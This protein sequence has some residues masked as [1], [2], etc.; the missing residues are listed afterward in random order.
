MKRDDNRK[1]VGGAIN[2][3]DLI[4][5][6]NLNV[7]PVTLRLLVNVNISSSTGSTLPIEVGHD[8]NRRTTAYGVA[9][10]AFVNTPQETLMP[11]LIDHTNGFLFVDI[12]LE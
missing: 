3:V 7:D 9:D 1:S 2:E 6:L 10:D 4:T 8:Q 11:L 12:L 5:P